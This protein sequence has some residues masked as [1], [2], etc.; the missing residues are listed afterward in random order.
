MEQDATEGALPPSRHNFKRDNNEPIPEPP[1]AKRSIPVQ[2]MSSKVLRQDTHAF[3]MKIERP[4]PVPPANAKPAP[5]PD[6]DFAEIDITKFKTVPYQ[7]KF[8][9]LN[10]GRT[11]YEVYKVSVEVRQFNYG[12][13]AFFMPILHLADGHPVYG[14]LHDSSDKAIKSILYKKVNA[15]ELVHDDE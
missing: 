2:P 7:M 13:Q 10:G 4:Y 14:K 3:M 15:K 12:S 8:I 9:T 5:T 1:P 11:W 6:A